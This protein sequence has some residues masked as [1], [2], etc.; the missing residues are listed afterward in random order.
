MSSS[1]SS[2]QPPLSLQDV[3][4]DFSRFPTVLS[5]WLINHSKRRVTDPHLVLP[6]VLSAVSALLG[7]SQVTMCTN[8]V[9]SVCIWT[10]AVGE[11]GCNKTGAHDFVHDVIEALFDEIVEEEV[12]DIFS[13]FVLSLF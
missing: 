13:F 5:E 3:E 6:Y 1:S 2:E 4:I 7:Y 8:W 10:I 12:I 11:S 9:I